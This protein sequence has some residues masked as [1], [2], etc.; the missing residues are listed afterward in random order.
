MKITKVTTLLELLKA[1]SENKPQVLQ[2]ETS[3]NTLFLYLRNYFF[4]SSYC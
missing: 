1:I 2:I 3:S 4:D